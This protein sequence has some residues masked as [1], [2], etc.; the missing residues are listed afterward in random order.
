MYVGSPPTVGTGD[1]VSV[2]AVVAEFRKSSRPNDLTLTELIGPAV[3]LLS[4]TNPLP[5]AVILGVDRAVPHRIVDSDALT[6]FDA[7]TDGV[8]L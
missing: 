2:R 7:T 1:S 8:F 3:T 5:K 6:R 4:R